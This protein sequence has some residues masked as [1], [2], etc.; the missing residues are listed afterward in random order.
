MVTATTENSTE[1]PLEGK[2]ELVHD[3]QGTNGEYIGRIQDLKT[4]MQVSMH[5]STIYNRHGSTEN[6]NGQ[7]KV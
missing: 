6:V 2:I 3:P 1:V 5:Y 4:Q 7:M